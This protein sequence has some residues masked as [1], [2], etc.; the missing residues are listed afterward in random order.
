MAFMTC[1]MRGL[2][3]SSIRNRDSSGAKC[4]LFP[5][6]RMSA[7]PI[8]NSESSLLSR[9]SMAWLRLRMVD[10]STSRSTW[11]R[12]S[13]RMVIVTRSLLILAHTL[14]ASITYLKVFCLK[15]AIPLLIGCHFMRIAVMGC[16]YVGLVLGTCLS[17]LG[18]EVVCVDAVKEKIESLRRGVIPIYEPGLQELV[19]KNAKAGR[20]SFSLDLGGA[21]EKSDVVFI[22]VG[23]P[24]S[25]DGDADLRFVIQVAEEIGKNMNGYKVIVNKSTVPVGTGSLVRDTV[26]KFYAGEVDVVSNP[27]FLR[28]G[29]AI[30]DFM[31]P[32]RV[33]IGNG[34]VAAEKRMRE[35]YAPLG[36]KMI[37]TDVKSAELIKYASNAFLATKISFINEIAN[38]C[39]LV[40][41]DV[42][43][44]AE[45]MG[46]DARIGPAFLN[47]GVGYGG[48][49]FP[50]DVKALAKTAE[51]AGYD[52]RI[53]KGVEEVNRLQKTLAVRKLEK[54]LGSLKGRRIGVLGLAFKPNTDDLR[55]APSL[56]V[57]RALKA[58]GALVSAMDPV[59]EEAAKKVLTGITYC[60]SVYDCAQGADALL[61]LTE[62]NEFKEIDFR[63]VKALMNG[64][65]IV[66][67]RNLYS[68]KQVEAAGFEYYGVGQ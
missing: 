60:E 26:T 3:C 20:L 64:R 58:K 37:F 5:P 49:C 57:I 63:K 46:L 35:I 40:G 43:K 44:V 48:S 33:V 56:E 19:E 30:N 29:S 39:D 16:G 36:A 25:V 14:Y 9:D 53:L 68:R 28:E 47:A 45:G 6:A 34:S 11:V 24:E 27:E 23:T 38:V 22:A 2:P 21:V 15:M 18:H 50:K 4:L 17:E 8:R 31:K 41:A 42:K 12:R 65:V 61:V 32:D 62:W 66:D 1:S 55:E 67:G 59:A 52:F 51:K 13:L 10:P 54:A 7:R